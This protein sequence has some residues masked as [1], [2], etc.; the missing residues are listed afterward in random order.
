M[1][2]ARAIFLNAV[3]ASFILVGGW[4]QVAAQPTTMTVI[5]ASSNNGPFIS[6]IWLGNATGFNDKLGIKVDYAPGGGSQ[7]VMQLIASKQG[8]A[9]QVSPIDLIQ[10][11]QRQPTLPLIVVYMHDIVTGYDL[12]VP[13][14]SPIKTIADMK[15]KTI[16]VLS[17]ASGTVGHA[18]AM[19]RTHGVDAASVTMVP[20]GVGGQAAAAISAKRVDIV[21]LPHSQVAVLETLGF[22]F[23]TFHPS[24][25]PASA[26]FVVHEDMLKTRR[27]DIVKLMQS[28]AYS[29]AFSQV[30]PEAAVYGFWQLY[31]KPT[32][33]VEKQLSNGIHAV[34]RN[35]EL[36][37]QVGNSRRWGEMIEADWR[38]NVEFMG[39]ESGIDAKTVDYSKLFTTGLLDDVNKVDTTAAVKEAREWKKPW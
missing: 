32:G 4:S 26:G 34:K 22:K 30:N 36:W 12:M 7:A 20:I 27:A 2:T 9:G 23:R 3:S 21:C 28:I 29:S 31:G 1:R 13:A 16:G 37:K 35:S 8:L 10:A 15:E 5:G 6:H 11:K 39:V 17:M 24:P 38:A 33:D 14:D 19:L 25:S 18:K